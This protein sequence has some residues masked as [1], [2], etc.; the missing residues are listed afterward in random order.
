MYC[1]TDTAGTCESGNLITF[2][3]GHPVVEKDDRQAT[4]TSL[5]PDTEF[6]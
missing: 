1:C 2:L 4:H 6:R 3:P 5:A